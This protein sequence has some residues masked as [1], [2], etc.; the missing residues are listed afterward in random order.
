MDIDQRYLQLLEAVEEERKQEESFFSTLSL[1]KSIKEKNEE[2]FAWYPVEITATHYAAGDQ[3]EVKIRRKN[4]GTKDV[5][6]KFKV[7]VA[8]QLFN[9][10]PDIQPVRGVVSFI[11]KENLSFLTNAD[12]E[13][14]EEFQKGITGIEIMYD[15]KPYQVMKSAL[16]KVVQSTR[17]SV[18]I[19]KK[20]MAEKKLE[21]NSQDNFAGHIP[22]TLVRINDSQ[23]EAILKALQ[24]KYLSIIHGPP[25]T[26]KTTTLVALC[27]ALVQNE[28]RIL[29][30]AS[31]N[32][33]VDLLAN[34]LHAEGLQVLRVGNIT[35]IHD[36]L[37]DLTLVEK[38]RSHPDWATI[39]KMRIQADQLSR[40]ASQFKRTFT[41]EDRENRKA[42]Q[43]EVREIRQWSRNLEE[44]ISDDILE[45][46]QVIA[47][48]LISAG[49][50]LVENLRFQTVVIDEASQAL[51][52]ECWNAILK[53]ERVI[54]A[55]DHHQLPPTIKSNAAREKGLETTMLDIMT[56]AIPATSLLTVQ[57]RMHKAILGFS[58]E[59]FYSGKLISSPKV[60]NRTLPGDE[61]P[62]IFVDTAGCGFEEIFNPKQKSYKN[63]G[64]YFIMREFMQQK[65]EL[66]LGAETGII[67]PYA[68]QVRYI[69]D[70]VTADPEW[71]GLDVEVNT[72]DGFQGQE[73]D[74][75]MVSLVRS[76]EKGEIGFLKD[77]RRLNVAM[78][79]ARKKLVL[80]GDSATIGVHDLFEKL[81]TYIEKN[82]GSDSAWN[83]M[84]YD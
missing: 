1:S 37:M 24:S 12:R 41:H 30:C 2:G 84:K 74:I 55:G 79:R 67:S 63:E 6:H 65:K 80:F 52:P 43:K 21:D 19:L 22:D 64:E 78:T 54:L 76:N 9:S 38:M 5:F 25:G 73:K 26:G 40:Q 46:S 27:K 83:Y 44:R 49:H 23:K 18:Q 68:E 60:E 70:E 81:L 16:V 51:E 39:K 11:Q 77:S 14:L 33:A 58:N 59:T 32:N 7:G 17:P 48:T 4:P 35:R 82:N 31:S 62:I 8:V 66:F 28:K 13:T 56:D 20:A 61:K 50:P 3:L 75:I 10:M 72:I 36:S 71:A 69:S 29:V 15:E 47:T 34:R 57:Y 42:I 53:A 45:K